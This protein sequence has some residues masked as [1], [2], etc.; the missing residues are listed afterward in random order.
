MTPLQRRRAGALYGLQYAT[1][2]WVRAF[3]EAASSGDAME[4]A[5][6]RIDEGLER[7]VIGRVI[8][9]LHLLALRLPG[10]REAM[11]IALREEI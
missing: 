5:G 11:T 10:A 7:E 8:A 9:E 1:S 4:V 3:D 2:A 6:E